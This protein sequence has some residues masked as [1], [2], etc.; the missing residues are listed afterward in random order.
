MQE[1]GITF[2]NVILAKVIR[3]ALRE[4]EIPLH[5]AIR[6]PAKDGAC[7]RVGKSLW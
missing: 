4:A 5:E 2:L 6:R 3:Y 7:P 1:S